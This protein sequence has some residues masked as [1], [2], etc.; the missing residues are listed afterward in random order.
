MATARYNLR[1]LM[2]STRR[3]KQLVVCLWFMLAGVSS[4]L[5][6]IDWAMPANELAHQIAALTGPGLI[7]LSYRNNASIPA[8]EV[9]AIRKAL[10][11]ALTSLGVTPGNQAS[12][13]V[14]TTV[15]VTLS[16][17]AQHGLW[18]A[19][20]RQGPQMRV[21]MVT[22]PNPAP[23]TEPQG[24]PVLLRSTLIFSQTQPILDAGLF[25]M[26]GDSSPAAHLVVLSPEQIAVYH[27]QEI[28]PG[29]WVKD[30]SFEIAHSRAYPRDV[31]GR[32]QSD[33]TALFKAYLPGAICTALA[34]TAGSGAPIDVSCMDSDDPWPIGSRRAFYNSGRNYFTGVITTPT[35]Q[36]RRRDGILFGGG[37]IPGEWDTNCLWRDKWAVSFIGWRHL[38]AVIWIA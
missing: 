21:A 14:A 10:E 26:A 7:S 19:E 12:A 1:H 31:R 13:D 38:K 16:S 9:P 11:V 6:A 30:Q 5:A 28:T 37:S 24:A 4:C 35:S 2:R 32:L 3:S 8:D 22:A 25:S 36:E 20:V 29:T 18:I 27:R 34:Q 15:Q 33:G 23:A 17:T